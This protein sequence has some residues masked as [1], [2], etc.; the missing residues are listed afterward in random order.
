MY[1]LM[2]IYQKLKQVIFFYQD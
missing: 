2:L 1:P